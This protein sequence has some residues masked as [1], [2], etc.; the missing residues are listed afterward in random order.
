MITIVFIGENGSMIKNFNTS[1]GFKER[2]TYIN[3]NNKINMQ[4]K[5]KELN[6]TKEDNNSKN[7]DIKAL[8][9]FSSSQKI[10][11]IRNNKF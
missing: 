7:Q 9:Q 6:Q 11:N 3:V 5:Q 4:K 10:D 2:W 1:D 8:H